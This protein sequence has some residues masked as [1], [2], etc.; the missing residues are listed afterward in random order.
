ML[1]ISTVS[2]AGSFELQTCQRKLAS[3]KRL[4]RFLKGQLRRKRC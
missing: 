3:E 4:S 1:L 2:K